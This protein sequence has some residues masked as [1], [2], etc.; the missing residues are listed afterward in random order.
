MSLSSPA[1]KAIKTAKGTDPSAVVTSSDQMRQ[2]L[3][4]AARVAASDTKVL[5]TGESGV[6]KDVVARY[7][8]A[9]SARRHREYVAVNCAGVTE[10]LLESELFGH[11]KGSFTGAHRDTRGKLQVA[12]HGT[13][14]LDEIGEMSGRMQG[15]L[16]RFLENGE[17]QP[18]GADAAPATANV[19]VIA[20]T[21]RNL[22]E[23]VAAGSFRN[24][25][26]YRLCVVHIHVPPLR[27]RPEDIR[28]L[29]AFFLDQAALRQATLQPAATRTTLTEEAWQLLEKYRW[30]GNVR[31]LQNVM[32][33]SI[34]LADPGDPLVAAQLPS[35]VRENR[36][37]AFSGG[38]RRHQVADELFAMLRQGKYTFWEP[39]HRMFLAHDLTRVDIR[40]LVRCALRVTRGNYRGVMTLFNIPDSDYKKFMNF[41]A[42]HGCG[43]EFREFRNPSSIPPR[44][45]R[46]PFPELLNSAAA[47]GDRGQPSTGVAPPEFDEAASPPV[48][49]SEST[50]PI[51]LERSSSAHPPDPPIPQ[52]RR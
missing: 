35:I 24:D 19:R 13:L 47:G 9:R 29:G 42:T 18:V 37:P 39:V 38:E 15:I 46:A 14:F 3:D 32:E 1:T 5:I 36:P 33:Q 30:P 21:N 34:W 40:E 25:L 7:I 10:S 51:R 6:G 2:L 8:H 45:R 11:V 26:L 31:E 20:A 49:S 22:A 50:L 48:E 44:I 43:A 4:Y 28:T 17:V 23:M 27:E 52:P 41:L 16:L 12:H